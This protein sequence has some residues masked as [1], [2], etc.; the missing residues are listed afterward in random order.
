MTTAAAD[1]LAAALK[2]SPEER[3]TLAGRIR[4]SLTPAEAW[5]SEVK[6]RLDEVADGAVRPVPWAEA[7][8]LIL[9]DDDA[10][11]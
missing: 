7:K 2:L 3:A 6:T 8:R 11:G 9:A 5:S 1:L 10:A 4:D